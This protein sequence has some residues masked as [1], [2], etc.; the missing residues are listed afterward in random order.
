MLK[1][2]VLSVQRTLTCDDD[3][4]LPILGTTSHDVVK[5]SLRKESTQA[6]A[7]TF[8]IQVTTNFGEQYLPMD[9]AFSLTTTCI[10][11]TLENWK[12]CK[13][14]V[15]R[16]TLTEAR[17][18]RGTGTTLRSRVRGEGGMGATLPWDRRKNC[19]CMTDWRL[20][21][22]CRYEKKKDAFLLN[23]K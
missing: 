10:G 22:K 15:K 21:L 5:F 12:T 7:F 4:S 2:R 13:A 6:A 3:K 1:C 16:T 8:Q 17:P 11:A 19:N 23:S 9:T 14:G 18:W 20:L